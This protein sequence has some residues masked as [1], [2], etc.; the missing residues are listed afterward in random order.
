M[1]RIDLILDILKYFM[2]AKLCEEILHYLTL[3]SWK[4]GHEQFAF[5]LIIVSDVYLYYTGDEFAFVVTVHITFV[6]FDI[7]FWVED[8]MQIFLVADD[9]C[10]EPEVLS[11]LTQDSAEIHHTSGKKL[12]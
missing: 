11:A 6:A 8:S 2:I 3:V 12:M 7:V 9:H 5:F 4:T 1:G 10:T